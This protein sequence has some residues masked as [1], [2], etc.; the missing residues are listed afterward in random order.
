MQ[1]IE[2]VSELL[3]RINGLKLNGKSIGLV[4]TMGALHE[5]HKALVDQSVKD[6]DVTVVSIFVNPIQ[7][8]N[9][10]D[11][12]KYPKTLEE[13]LAFLKSWGTTLVFVPDEADMYP[14]KPL[15]KL[16][17]GK[18][19]EVL[20][21]KFRPGH[22]TGVGIVVLKFFNLVKPDRAYFGL[23]DF[24]QYLVIKELV[25]TFS[26]PVKIV[27]VSTQRTDSGLAISSR[28]RNLS[29]KGLQIAS[30]IFKGLNIAKELILDKMSI[31]HTI[32]STRQFYRQ[33]E[34]LEIEYLEILDPDTLD[35][36]ENTRSQ[37]LLLSVA[38]Y[39]ENIRLIDNLYL[40]P[41]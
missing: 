16:D 2:S 28:N 23:K 37:P 19:T 33:V 25:D 35:T 14:K 18:I 21:G 39:V 32:Q 6:N 29:E 3:T 36:T 22:F 40:Q 10:E 27:G 7:F 9:R 17:F 1:K 4:P 20:E 30:N 12:L 13:D 5:G 11:L 38:G 26:I 31:N 15:I 8:N 24:Q 41:D 34:G